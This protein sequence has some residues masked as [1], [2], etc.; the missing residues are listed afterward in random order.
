MN[1]NNSFR[2]S[3]KKEPGKDDN[4]RVLYPVQSIFVI[5]DALSDYHTPRTSYSDSS[6]SIGPAAGF[7]IAGGALAIGGAVAYWLAHRNKDDDSYR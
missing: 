6:P 4:G 1:V 7:A 5:S 2:N 3:L